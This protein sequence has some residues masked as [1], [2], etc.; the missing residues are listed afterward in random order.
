MCASIQP[1]PVPESLCTSSRCNTSSCS[2]V[3]ALGSRRKWLKTCVRCLRPPQASSPIT[4]GCV[5]TWPT[6]SAALSRVSCCRKWSIQTEVSTNNTSAAASA[7]CRDRT[8]PRASAGLGIASAKRSKP[9]RALA[10]DQGL[11]SQVDQGSLLADSRKRDGAGEQLIIEYHSRAHMY[12]YARLMHNRN[13]AQGIK[14]PSSPATP[15]RAPARPQ[16]PCTGS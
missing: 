10:G 16:T 11:E 8:A 9:T 14:T 7:R 1:N 3:D 5:N 12:Q 13:T 2:A 4:K 15:P 6:S